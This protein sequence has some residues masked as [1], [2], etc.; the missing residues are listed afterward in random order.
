MAEIKICSKCR[1]S[2]P[3]EDIERGLAIQVGDKWICRECA[4]VGRRH[5][6]PFHQD[7]LTSL[8]RLIVEV[9]NVIR[10]ISFRESSIWTVFGAVVQVFVFFMVFVA[11]M[12]WANDFGTKWLL[13][14]AVCQLMAMTF[15]ILGK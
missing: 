3:E 10:T 1:R 12:N 5:K 7:V 8:E 13:A 4:A 14:A 11:Y 6:D 15:F 9:Q 2:I